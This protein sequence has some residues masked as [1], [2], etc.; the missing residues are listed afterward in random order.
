MA[1]EHRGFGIRDAQHGRM[2]GIADMPADGCGSAAG[3]G[4]AHHP[5]WHGMA[6]VR[7][8]EVDAVCNIVAIA[9]VA[10]A[11]GISELIDIMATD[12]ARD[13]LSF[14]VD[15]ARIDNLVT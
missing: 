2:T 9:P 13:P 10:C 12:L 6:F 3:S 4:A 7:H 5:E 14:R 8:L 11:F 1:V 15:H